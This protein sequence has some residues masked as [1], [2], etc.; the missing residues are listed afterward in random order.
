MLRG[1]WRI[2]S[3]II[4]GNTIKA[5]YTNDDRRLETWM[6]LPEKSCIW[7]ETWRIRNGLILLC[8]SGTT[9][10]QTFFRDSRTYLWEHHVNISLSKTNRNILE[11][12]INPKRGTEWL[13]EYQ[14][15]LR[16][17]LGKV[18]PFPPH[19]QPP[20]VVFAWANVFFSPFPHLHH[21]WKGA[22]ATKEKNS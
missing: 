6:S 2:W 18:R 14:Q 15:G 10:V 5:V 4:R 21:I 9:K 3:P 22:E 7:D 13:E 16:W 20:I 8:F 12:P 17:D 19:S 1:E 11:P